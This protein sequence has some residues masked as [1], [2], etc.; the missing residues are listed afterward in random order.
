MKAA[1]QA[2][3]ISMK[4]QLLVGAISF[5]NYITEET[6]LN[7]K[8]FSFKGHE[9]QRFILEIIENNPGCTFSVSKCSQIGL[10]ELFNR[11]ILALM[12]IKAGTAAIVSFPSKTFAQEVIKT[13]FARVIEDSP[14]LHAL[15]NPNIDSSSTKAFLNGSIMYGLGGNPGS[16]N[17]LLNRPISVVLVDEFD[18]QDVDITS[19]YRSRMTHTLAAERLIMNISTPTVEGIGINAEI[20]ECRTVYTPWI[21]CPCGHEFIGDYYLHVRVPGFS[22]DL[23]LLTKAKAARLDLSKAYLE[24]PDCKKNINKSKETVWKISENEEG[25]KNKIGIVLDPF[26]A[27]DFIP[28]SDLVESSLSYTS[29]VEFLNQGLGKVADVK[30][31]TIDKSHIHFQHDDRM[32]MEIF[33]LDLGKLCHFMR[34]RLK[35]DTTIHVEESVIIPL[36]ELEE[37]LAIQFKTRTFAAGV[38]DSQPYTDLVYKFVKRY[39][40]L[41]SAIYV[42]PVTP[43]PEIF[44]LSI[45]DKYGEEV[46]QIAINKPM[47]MTNLAGD[48]NDFYTFEPGMND[49]QIRQHFLDMRKVRDYRYEEMRYKWVKSAKGIDHFWHSAVYLSMAAKVAQAGIAYTCAIP[50]VVA[51]MNPERLRDENKRR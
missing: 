25:V 20:A 2:F 27:M 24:C 7:G 22:E 26:V 34:G 36:P 9:F 44:T 16:K 1:I 51:A 5:I 11:V 37:F 18:R 40:R 15:T 29:L 14:A 39:P 41:F 28:M 8:K 49:S 6:Y 50:V 45:N 23:K 17:T 30:D 42:D 48:L 21:K 47:A 12:A 3:V 31:S 19:G 32:G 35:F 33:G 46:R 4:A 38:C 13:R 10:S 43:K